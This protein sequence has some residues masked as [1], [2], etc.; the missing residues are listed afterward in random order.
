[1]GASSFTGFKIEINDFVGYHLVTWERLE[2]KPPEV[3]PS[4]CCTLLLHRACRHT[5]SVLWEKR[6]VVQT[7]AACW[8]LQGR[9]WPKYC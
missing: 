2:M 7:Q 5:D 6:C 9:Q 1:V 8:V 4:F 3:L